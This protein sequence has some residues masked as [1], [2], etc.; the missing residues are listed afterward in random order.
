MIFHK[1]KVRKRIQETSETCSLQ[2]IVPEELKNTFLYKPGQ[3]LTLKLLIDGDEERRAYSIS[4]CPTTDDFIQI[5]IKN[6]DGGFVSNYLVK[7]VTEDDELE[8]LPPLGNFTVEPKSENKIQYVMI[9]GGSGI[10]PLMSMIKSILTSEPLSKIILLY[11]NKNERNIIF[12]DELNKLLENYPNSLK[13]YHFIS[14]QEHTNNEYFGRL[15]S[16]LFKNLI[17]EKIDNPKD[18]EYYLCGPTSLM[19]SIEQSL[20]DYGILKEKIH[21]ES[22]VS[23]NLYDDEA[24]KQPLPDFETRNIKVRVYG[25][26]YEFTVENDENIITAGIKNGLIFP[27]SC[28]IGAC[29]T[30][31]AMLVSGNV[32]ME[33]REGL[34][35]AEVEQGYILTCQAHPMS[36]DVIVDFDY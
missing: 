22:F 24:A 33:I 6:I 30:C 19:Q 7:N 15:N 28:Q 36:D 25:Q 11:S 23:S 18:A 32:F 13:I 21:K 4:S 3:Y 2:F 17:L 12:K 20:D 29:S 8:V 35:D 16:E 27:Y 14:N 31:R 26:E 1:L 9:A 34:T 10:T 5:T